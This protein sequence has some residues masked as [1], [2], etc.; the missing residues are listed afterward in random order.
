MAHS[1]RASVEK[2]HQDRM[3]QFEEVY[4]VKFPENSGDVERLD[5]DLQVVAQ[6]IDELHLDEMTA[7]YKSES[8]RSAPSSPN[9][10]RSAPQRQAPTP[11]AP[12]PAAS[13]QSIQRSST[14]ATKLTLTDRI[15]QLDVGQAKKQQLE[16]A[17]G[18]V[19][20]LKGSGKIEQAKM[21]LGGLLKQIAFFER[22]QV[23]KTRCANLVGRVQQTVDK[24]RE[25]AERLPASGRR[26]IE[27]SLTEAA[28]QAAAL[29]GALTQHGQVAATDLGEGSLSAVDQR[30]KISSNPDHQNTQQQHGMALVGETSSQLAG[31]AND[32]ADEAQQSGDST[33]GGFLQSLAKALIKLCNAVAS[34]LGFDSSNIS[35]AE[36][37]KLTQQSESLS[38]S[39]G[40]QDIEIVTI[41]G[42]D[43]QDGMD[44]TTR[45]ESGSNLGC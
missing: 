8:Q 30:G 39:Q 45:S 23:F 22:Q 1:S 15:E 10:Q 26:K 28:R 3:V 31:E 11:S 29:K 12:P 43:A 20:G 37:S 35:D 44:E 36:N 6:A 25:M 17:L 13:S 27:P 16:T 14:A 34:A 5:E 9:S 4:G 24:T 7:V 33:S 32:L 19:K 38:S 42:Q 18:R 40:S 2:M 21:A 41:R